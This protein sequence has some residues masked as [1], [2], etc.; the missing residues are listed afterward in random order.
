[1]IFPTLLLVNL[2]SHII[3]ENWQKSPIN[4]FDA[5]QTLVVLIILG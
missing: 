2:T 5:A 4:D 1:M 3:L